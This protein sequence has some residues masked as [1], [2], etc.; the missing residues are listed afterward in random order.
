MFFLPLSCSEK[1]VILRTGQ[2]APSFALSDISGK[3]IRVPEDVKGRITAI[4]FW[5]SSCKFCAAEM[6]EIEEVYKKYAD[7][8]LVILAVNIGEDKG[9]VEK[10][11][12]GYNISYPMLL[13][14]GQIV[15][16]RY[17]V[18]STPETFLLDR[19]GLIR[20]KILGEI[21]RQT[22]EEIVIECLKEEKT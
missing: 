13:D 22:F 4:R 15:T 11:A 8:G 10:F 17:G 3:M 19:N 6:P 20:Q 5:A 16:K 14:P 21:N 12:K 1:G 7:K 9:D 2:P 18:I